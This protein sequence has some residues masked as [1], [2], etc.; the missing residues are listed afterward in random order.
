MTGML[1]AT[2]RGEESMYVII[3]ERM[4]ILV[5]ITERGGSDGA[6]FEI[7]ECKFLTVSWVIEESDEVHRR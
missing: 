4:R 3:R 2:R 1:K 7:E 6:S 5:G